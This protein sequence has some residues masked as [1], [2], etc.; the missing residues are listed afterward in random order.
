MTVD[1]VPASSAPSAAVSAALPTSTGVVAVCAH[2]DDESF[3]LGAVLG[4]LAKAG[5]RTGVLCFTHGEASTLHATPGELA[6]V[7]VDELTR[8]AAH[9]GVGRAELLTYPDAGLA[10]QPLDE[11]A[12]HVRSLAD[13]VGADTL[14]VFDLGGITGHPDHQRATDAALA[15]ALDSRYSVLAWTLPDTVAHALN[16]E[17]GT[18]FVGR[19]D[20]NVDLILPVDRRRQL[21]AIHHHA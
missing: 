16:A 9:L 4:M 6:A 14:V 15:A 18:A 20:H 7:R 8:A 1:P 19:A 13:D 10:D 21:G 5:S 2:P 12:R 17:F 3:G 11:L